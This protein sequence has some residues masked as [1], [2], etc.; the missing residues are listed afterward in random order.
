MSPLLR[1]L[2]RVRVIVTLL[3]LGAIGW[4]VVAY[5]RP[6]AD[7]LVLGDSTVAA[8]LGSIEDTLL[9]TGLVRPSVTIDLRSEASGIV[10]SV[11]VQDGDRVEAGQEL[12]RLDSRI[13]QTAVQEA[14]ANLKQA[15]MQ[16][17]AGEIDLDEDTVMLRRKNL[18]RA[19]SLF[20]RG[21]VPRADLEARAL[22]LRVAERSLER[23]RRNLETNRARIDQLAAAVERAQAQLQHTNIRSPLDAWVI[24]RQVEVGSGV[25]GVSQS[26]SG[27]TVIVT[28]GDARQASLQAKVTAAD[29][30]RLKAGMKARLRLDS[31]PGQVRPGR[32]QSVATAGEQD[33]ST[34]L[35]TFPVVVAL[36]GAADSAW[37]NVPAQVEIVLA[38]RDDVIV[39]PDGCVRTDAS[40]RTQVTIR[41]AGDRVRSQTVEIGAVDPDR[42]EIT[43]GLTVGQTLACR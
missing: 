13:A 42:L 28:L 1:R 37:I 29:A 3:V 22:E 16:Q 26:S 11:S 15:E 39:V 38:V 40:G 20:E 35:T 14:E 24:K 41:E 32:V 21:L 10:E 31:E 5:S 19:Q 36:E 25:A 2:V 6:P 17:A 23:A 18:E 33:T 7:A 34:R 43:T 12:L 8:T 27:G 9:V 30:R 4:A